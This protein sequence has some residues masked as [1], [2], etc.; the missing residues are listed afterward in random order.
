MNLT[1]E[2][3][4]LYLTLW[5]LL[6]LGAA[7]FFSVRGYRHRS[8]PPGLA[9]SIAPE[10]S[11]KFTEVIA[12]K[13][14]LDFIEFV[15]S[16]HPDFVKDVGRYPKQLSLLYA[17]KR[18]TFEVDTGEV[19]LILAPRSEAVAARAV[20]RKKIDFDSVHVRLPR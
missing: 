15:F 4:R 19:V 2:E 16:L 7:V 5:G 17:L 18:G 13:K 3:R 1:P 6:A 14:G 11:H 20:N 12:S 9:V 10:L 8:T